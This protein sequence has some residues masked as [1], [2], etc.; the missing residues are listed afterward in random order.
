MKCGT[1]T[2]YKYLAGHP[3]VCRCATK[4]PEFFSEHQGHKRGGVAKYGDLWEFYPNRHRYVVEASTGYT[5][6][7]REQ[8]VA[9]RMRDYGIDPKFIYIVRDPYS[10]IE[11]DYN[12][13]LDKLWF[14]PG[15]AITSDRYVSIS[16]YY[17]QLQQYR[18]IFGRERILVLDFQELSRE[19]G[20]LLE[21]VSRFLGLERLDAPREPRHHHATS[22]LTRGEVLVHRTAVLNALYRRC[23]LRLQWAIRDRLLRRTPVAPRR[24]LTEAERQIVHDK[25]NA[26]M[27]RFAREYDFDVAQ[28]G[29]RRE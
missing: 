11:S 15:D 2:L 21:R 22:P 3:Q 5:K 12:W 7:P 14:R 13:S 17:V 16:N 27:L 8:N 26:D 6:F 19:P 25:L 9:G 28:W 24:T 23:P 4:E 10:R 18:E 1:S 20:R 29:F